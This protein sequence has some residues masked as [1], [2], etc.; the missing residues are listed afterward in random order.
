MHIFY[1][2]RHPLM[3]LHGADSHLKPSIFPFCSPS[4]PTAHHPTTLPD[5]TIL[6]SDRLVTRRVQPAGC[7]V[8][9]ARPRDRS[10]PLLWTRSP[11]SWGPLGS[12]VKSGN[13]ELASK[14]PKIFKNDSEGYT[15]MSQHDVGINGTPTPV[16][17]NV[18]F[19]NPES[20]IGG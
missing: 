8:F 13:L 15:K 20:Q 10:S 18:C 17:A 11:N 12:D 9:P 5:P 3:G 6:H 14:A 1:T 16:T 4:D 19:W 2:I 7:K